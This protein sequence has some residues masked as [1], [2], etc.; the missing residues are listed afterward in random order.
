MKTWE[1][2]VLFSLELSFTNESACQPPIGETEKIYES[3]NDAFNPSGTCF[4][5][6]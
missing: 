2:P 3:G 6:S 4:Y 1:K 5:V